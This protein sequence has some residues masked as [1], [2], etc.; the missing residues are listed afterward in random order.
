MGRFTKIGS[1]TFASFKYPGF[2]WLWLSVSLNGYA[3]IVAQIAIG[4]LALELTGSA[5]GVGVAVASRHLPKIFLGVPFGVLSDRYDRCT[6]LQYTNF[7][8]TAVAAG[9]VFA[10]LTG[11]LSFGVLVCIAVAVGILDVAET[12]VSRAQVYDLV[13]SKQ[14]LNGMSLVILSNMVS[15]G[16]W[17]FECIC[18]SVSGTDGFR[19]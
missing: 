17:R 6:I 12:S 1:E 7:S 18:R 15:G 3:N 19:R 14:A 5:L 16:A 8:G 11:N 10:G 9:A 13:G 4:W 2:I